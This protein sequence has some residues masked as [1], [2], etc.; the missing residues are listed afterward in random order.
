MRFILVPKSITQPERET[1]QPKKSTP[2]PPPTPTPLP[3][4]KPL[5][6]KP[7]QLTAVDLRQIESKFSQLDYE[8]ALEKPD[9]QVS[10]YHRK[11]RHD[12]DDGDTLSEITDRTTLSFS[13]FDRVFKDKRNHV[14]SPETRVLET[15]LQSQQSSPKQ[16]EANELKPAEQA[17]ELKPAEQAIELKPAEQAI[18]LKPADEPQ[19]ETL[20]PI[21]PPALIEL[22]FIEQDQDIP[23]QEDFAIEDDG[24]MMNMDYDEE[25][26]ASVED[27]YVG[28]A[29]TEQ[30]AALYD[31][32]PMEDAPV[33]EAR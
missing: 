7:K 6:Q 31:H 22:P 9:I 21:I 25:E 24:L 12:E 13:R 18:E 19:T 11:H 2:A 30:N 1:T 28:Y 20:E 14:L 23:L 26:E 15:Q 17:I 27:A 32:P 3:T 4:I 8:K 33:M 16:H 29:S 5:I 10:F